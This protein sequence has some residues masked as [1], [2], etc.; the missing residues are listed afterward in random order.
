M[1]NVWLV[2]NISV[3]HLGSC[4]MTQVT[5]RSQSR[6]W[7]LLMA[8]RQ[9]GHQKKI[10]T[11]GNIACVD[12]IRSSRRNVGR[13]LLMLGVH[14]IT[15]GPMGLFHTV[16]SINHWWK[17]ASRYQYLINMNIC[18]KMG[19]GLPLRPVETMKNLLIVRLC[20]ALNQWDF[21]L[22]I[23]KYLEMWHPVRC[24]LNFRMIAEIW[25]SISC[26]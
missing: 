7:W 13:W 1:I 25:T 20:K 19:G 14:L 23:S 4:S 9:A 2:A 24:L 5:V 12:F 18:K 3:T 22:R 17:L 26:L 10:I 15:R 11:V 6:Q 21:E 16:H 8:W